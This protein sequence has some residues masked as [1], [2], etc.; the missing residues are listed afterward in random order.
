MLHV[1]YFYK[2]LGHTARKKRLT[3]KV[4]KDKSQR[5]TYTQADVL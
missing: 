5:A 2:P 4:I 1:A 3:A